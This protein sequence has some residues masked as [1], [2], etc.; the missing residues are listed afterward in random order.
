L[1]DCKSLIEAFNKSAIIMESI[2][3][4][5]FPNISENRSEYSANVKLDKAETK[6]NTIK[7]FIL[8]TPRGS[9]VSSHD[10]E[11]EAIRAFKQSPNN[12]GMKI[13]R[14]SAIKKDASF[15]P[16]KS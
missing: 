11:S 3:N 2:S 7:K 10:S 1:K 16:S 5:T 4:N 8:K 9:N 12:T 13:V 6:L 14:E 15:T